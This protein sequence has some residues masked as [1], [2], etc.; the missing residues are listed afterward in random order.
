MIQMPRQPIVSR[1]AS[2]SNTPTGHGQAG[3]PGGVAD[4]LD[5]FEVGGADAD[6]ERLQDRL[7]GGEAR[8]QA[9]AGIPTRLGIGALVVGEQP[10]GQT[11]T[12]SEDGPE[13]VDVDGVHPDAA[14]P[15]FDHAGR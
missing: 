2:V 10:A 7:F 11:G 9:G 12:A 1:K 5:V 15:T 13:T 14:D 3:R 4:D 8:R 6:P